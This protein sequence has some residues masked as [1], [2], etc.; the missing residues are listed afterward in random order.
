MSVNRT[1]YAYKRAVNTRS[2]PRKS[3][4]L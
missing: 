4:L 3:V 2:G 1:D